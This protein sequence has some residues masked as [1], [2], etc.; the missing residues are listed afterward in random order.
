MFILRAEWKKRILT[1]ICFLQKNAKCLEWSLRAYY[2]SNMLLIRLLYFLME[3]TNKILQVFHLLYIFSEKM[4]YW[5]LLCYW[6]CVCC[7]N[8]STFSTGFYFSFPYTN[9]ISIAGVKRCRFMLQ[10]FIFQQ[11]AENMLIHLYVLRA[12]LSNQKY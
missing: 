8:F 9:F 5:P 3:R 7:A 1:F 4:K 11:R 12:F 2:I 10:Y 6:L